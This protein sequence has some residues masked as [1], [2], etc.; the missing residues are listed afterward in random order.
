MPDE[1][2]WDVM[3]RLRRGEGGKPVQAPAEPQPSPTRPS[4][5]EEEAAAQAKREQDMRQKYEMW[6]TH[7]RMGGQAGPDVQAWM[8]AMEQQY[9]GWK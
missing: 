1:S 9:P 3:G 5:A 6:R 8:K 4:Q 2:F 7:I